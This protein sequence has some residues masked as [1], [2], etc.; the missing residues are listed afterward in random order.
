MREPY[1]S[2]ER[3]GALSSQ[4]L[5]LAA[6]AAADRHAVALGSARRCAS[7]G[8]RTFTGQ[9]VH[10]RRH[11]CRVETVDE[12]MSLQAPAIID[13]FLTLPGPATAA[14]VQERPGQPT[15]ST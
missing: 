1:R 15:S 2:A 3:P 7:E 10:A 14:T 5:T 8:L 12:N 6:S 11:L 4:A 9:F 13:F